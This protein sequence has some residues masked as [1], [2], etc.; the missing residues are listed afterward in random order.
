MIA[1]TAI[2]RTAQ[3]LDA[4]DT[5]IAAGDLAA[6]DRAAVDAAVWWTVA[7]AQ[8]VTTAEIRAHRAGGEAR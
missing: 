7:H 3:A 2:A 6:A 8:G 1:R 4:V 5:A